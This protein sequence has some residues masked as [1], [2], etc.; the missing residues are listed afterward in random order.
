MTRK[1]TDPQLNLAAMAV[2]GPGGEAALVQDLAN[3]LG[4][5]GEGSQRGLSAVVGP[6][7][8]L[9]AAEK[10]LACGFAL[11]GN[12]VALKEV[13]AQ[14]MATENRA[15]IEALLSSRLGGALALDSQPP[16]PR[17]R[18]VAFT[19]RD[20]ESLTHR[21]ELA[22]EVAA[23]LS[24]AD[25]DILRVLICDGSLAVAWVGVFRTKP[26]TTCDRL[27]MQSVVPLLQQRLNQ[28][29]RP[30]ETPATVVT[31]T[32]VLESLGAEAF[33]MRGDGIVVHANVAGRQLLERDPWGPVSALHESQSGRNP[34]DFYVTPVRA[35]SSTSYFLVIR[36]TPPVDPQQRSAVL[37]SRYHLT[38]RQREVLALLAR[39]Q[40]NK[41]IGATLGCTE[42]T[43]ELHVSAI[44]IK[45]GCSSRAEAVA[46]FWTES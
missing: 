30:A 19:G 9:L 12:G 24:I 16:D 15:A 25:L 7:T 46:R 8:D 28:E 2:R 3:A 13:Y 1:R 10:T 34:A 35:P 21:A 18:N 40:G 5:V 44:L 42:G 32:D 37:A 38:D 29:H 43:V 41:T 11:S 6:L 17:E 31:V 4:T 26:F 14:G 33:V 20:M 45:L 23:K 39:G 27:L 36:R 22:R